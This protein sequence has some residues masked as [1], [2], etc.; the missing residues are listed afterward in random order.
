[1]KPIAI[2]A[3]F[4]AGTCIGLYC[5]GRIEAGVLEHRAPRRVIV[6]RE[7]KVIPADPRCHG[8]RLNGIADVR[9]IPPIPET[10]YVK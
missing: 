8:Y 5:G 6:Y 9:C 3:A 4:I 7:P 1:M 10:Y 2:V